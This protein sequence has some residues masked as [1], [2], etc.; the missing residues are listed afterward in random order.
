MKIKPE[1]EISCTITSDKCYKC[2]I[3]GFLA[4]CYNYKG[5][6]LTQYSS[7]EIHFE[8]TIYLEITTMKYPIL[9]ISQV[10]YLKISFIL[11]WNKYVYV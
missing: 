9:V 4:G 10:K 6:E 2:C 3:L 7:S 5:N 1:I 11:G 8:I